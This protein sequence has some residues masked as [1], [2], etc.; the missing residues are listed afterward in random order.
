[1]SLR[2]PLK[3]RRILETDYTSDDVRPETLMEALMQSRPGAT[4]QVSVE[5]VQPLLDVLDYV[6]DMLTDEQSYLI[7]AIA[8]E[9]IGYQE[10]GDRLGVSRTH[11][12]RLHNQALTRLRYLCMNHPPT[13]ERLGMEPTWNSAS[14]AELLEI[15]GSMFDDDEPPFKPSLSDAAR[16]IE[17]AV[18]AA[19]YHL[20]D[21]RELVAVQCL[22]QAAQYAVDYLRS[23]GKWSFIGMHELLVSKQNDYGHGNILKF[24][25]IGV[26][27]RSTDKIERIKN[28]MKSK[29]SPRNES[30][31]DSFRDIIGYAVIARMLKAE[32][33]ELGLDQ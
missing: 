5:E 6:S 12:W 2:R 31:L 33:F 25:M 21:E 14:M 7:D 8:F 1:M 29:A 24:G 27:V 22:T 16:D 4:E 15:A 26:V 17:V 3:P 11:A 30:L 18:S 23:V 32:T 10:L 20:Q 13:R 19:A 28:L 9:Q